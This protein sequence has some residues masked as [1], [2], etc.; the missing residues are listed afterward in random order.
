MNIRVLLLAAALSVPQF[1]MASEVFD[2]RA[3]EV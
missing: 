1:A 3:V 2:A